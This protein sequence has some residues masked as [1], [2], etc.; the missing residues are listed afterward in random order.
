MKYIKKYELTEF[1]EKN[2]IYSLSRSIKS[3]MNMYLGRIATTNNVNSTSFFYYTN[4]F[5]KHIFTL[6]GIDHY[7]GDADKYFEFNLNDN[8]AKN[9]DQKTYNMIMF[10]NSIMDKY[11]DFQNLIAYSKI[12]NIIKDLSKEAYEIFIQR[13]KYNL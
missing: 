4:I 5:K 12:D 8:N 6:Q 9:T 7:Q 3:F 11:K 13:I 10:I 2:V 1:E